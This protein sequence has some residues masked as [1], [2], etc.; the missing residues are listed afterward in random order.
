MINYKESIGECIDYNLISHISPLGWEHVNMLG[1]YNFN[2]NKLE[3]T[4]L[5]RTLNI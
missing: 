4:E 2:L 3:S 1:E 5:H